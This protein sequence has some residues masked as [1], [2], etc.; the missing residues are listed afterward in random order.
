MEKFHEKRNLHWI[1]DSKSTNKDSTISAVNALKGNII[2][3][4]GG[5]SKTNNY[6]DLEKIVN[7][8]SIYLIL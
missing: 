3:I 2:L 6:T 8:K 5:R 1:N 7:K 4:L